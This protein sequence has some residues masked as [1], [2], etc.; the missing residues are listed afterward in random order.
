MRGAVGIENPAFVDFLDVDNDDA[1][2]LPDEITE[3]ETEKVEDT[4]TGKWE[5]II[6]N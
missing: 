2:S 6:A 4:T 1:T 5:F 3:S